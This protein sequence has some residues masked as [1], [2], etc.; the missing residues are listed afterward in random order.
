MRGGRKRG[1]E[2][3]RPGGPATCDLGQIRVG[4]RFALHEDEETV[5]DDEAALTRR[6][7]MSIPLLL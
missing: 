3:G 5:L 4:T 6:G 2:R 7:A 1:T